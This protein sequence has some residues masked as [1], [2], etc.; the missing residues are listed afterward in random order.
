MCKY[1]TQ[2]IVQI[3]G[4]PDGRAQIS[5]SPYPCANGTMEAFSQ[6]LI[7]L[8]CN[9]NCIFVTAAAIAASFLMSRMTTTT[10]KE[11]R[12]GGT[13]GPKPLDN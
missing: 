10:A 1:F 4:N 13:K 6:T 5:P 8:A 11:G 2:A 7:V 9:R 12:E 3:I